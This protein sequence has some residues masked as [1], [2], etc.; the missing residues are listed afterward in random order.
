VLCIALG[1]AVFHVHL[2]KGFQVLDLV[3]KEP[4]GI[5]P[6]VDFVLSLSFELPDLKSWMRHIP[7]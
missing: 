6:V 3:E 1:Q 4:L 2:G 7:S 5:F